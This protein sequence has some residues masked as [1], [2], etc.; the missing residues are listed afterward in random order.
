MK[1]LGDFYPFHYIFHK[2]QTAVLEHIHQTVFLKNRK[3]I[4]RDREISKQNPKI[5]LKIFPEAVFSG[6]LLQPR[7]DTAAVPVRAHLT[8]NM[9]AATAWQKRLSSA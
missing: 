1:Q 9:P 7:F 4:R 3:K 2:F 6:I 5:L 8:L